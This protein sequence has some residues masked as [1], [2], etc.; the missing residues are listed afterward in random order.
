M[1]RHSI[2]RVI[3]ALMCLALL[4][5]MAPATA[6]GR[7]HKE[8]DENQLVPALSPTFAP[9]DCKAKLTGPV[10]TGERHL[11][12]DWAPIA[13]LCDV[14]IWGSRVEHRYQ[15]RYY[16]HDNLNYYRE[17]RTNDIDYLSTSPTGEAAASISTN[18]RFFETFD[19]RG[20]DQTLT[21]TT[22]GVIWDLRPAQGPAIFRAVGTLVEPYNAAPTFSGHATINGD[23]TRYDDAPLE[24]VITEEIFFAAA[25][26]AATSGQ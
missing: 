19:V 1:K 12:D 2:N 24:S 18:V 9:W 7:G 4:I 17:F 3:G 6:F 14:P 13:D 22:N 10:C 25:C 23:T 11:H 15:I 21:I 20:D 16:D 26:Q 5:A 8:V